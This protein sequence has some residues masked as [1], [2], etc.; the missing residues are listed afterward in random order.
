MHKSPV[1]YFAETLLTE[2][3]MFQH[4]NRYIYKILTRIK[5]KM[6]S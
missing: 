1:H 2:P 4:L 6:E 5:M 3:W